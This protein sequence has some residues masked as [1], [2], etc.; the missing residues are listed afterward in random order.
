MFDGPPNMRGRRPWEISEYIIDELQDERAYQ[1][2]CAWK[3]D[4]NTK[5][6]WIA[7][8]TKYAGQANHIDPLKFREQML[9][10]ATVA[11]AAVETLDKNN[12][13]PQ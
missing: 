10:V 13:I 4:Q 7:I 1:H 12:G 9:K 11:C 6:D 5:S 3:D 2:S 8:I